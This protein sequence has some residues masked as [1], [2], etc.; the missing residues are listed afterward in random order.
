MTRW[1]L[2]DS[3]QFHYL[4]YPHGLGIY[5]NKIVLR[6]CVCVTV[7]YF[8]K[9]D[10]KRKRWNRNQI[11][12]NMSRYEVN[13]FFVYIFQILYTVSQL[14]REKCFCITALCMNCLVYV[15]TIKYNIFYRFKT[16]IGY[17]EIIIAIE[18]A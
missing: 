18:N 5:R 4:E 16:S 2:R 15:Y 6:R 12:T 9:S 17:M 11:L 7:M 8:E 13:N 1:M 14:E 3:W 10:G